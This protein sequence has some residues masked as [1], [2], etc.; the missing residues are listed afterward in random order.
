MRAVRPYRPPK[1]IEEKP[2][3]CGVKYGAI[4]NLNAGFKLRE[5][6]KVPAVNRQLFDLLGGDDAL[7]GSLLR[8][9]LYAGGFNLHRSA[10]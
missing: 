6:E 9:H 8:I 3:F 1:E 4:L 5:L 2:F 7:D 10:G